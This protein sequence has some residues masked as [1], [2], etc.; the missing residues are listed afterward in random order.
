MVGGFF[1]CFYVYR[2]VG[3][4]DDDVWCKIIEFFGLVCQSFGVVMQLWIGLDG[5]MI[6]LVFVFD[7]DWFEEFCGFD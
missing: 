7:E 5:E 4:F 3:D 2:G 1:D 6:V